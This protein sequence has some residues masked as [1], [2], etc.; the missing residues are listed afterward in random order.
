MALC[1]FASIIILLSTTH[2]AKP[3]S[4]DS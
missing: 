4:F 1:G 2:G 3:V